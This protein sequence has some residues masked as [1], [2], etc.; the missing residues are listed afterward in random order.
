MAPRQITGLH[1]NTARR[2]LDARQRLLNTGLYLSHPNIRNKV[3]WVRDGKGHKL[4][5]KNTKPVD[6]DA[7]KSPPEM[8]LLSLITVISVDDFWMSP[9]AG[10]K[11]PTS[12]TKTLTDAKASCTGEKP[13]I[14]I[15]GDDFVT[16]ITNLQWLQDQT[17]THGFA[18]K[19]GAL[20]GQPGA[21]ADTYKVKVR[22]C[23]F[24][25]SV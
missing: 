13:K 15:F 2:L 14:D 10:W 7:E 11:G 16:A 18:A 12:F 25:V 23:L 9:D 1:P 22:H 17:A 5:V 4:V 19:K 6:D 21:A 8:A 24:E 20:I 3:E